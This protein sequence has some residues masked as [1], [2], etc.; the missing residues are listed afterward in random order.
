MTT[1][2]A[3]RDAMACD[4]QATAGDVKWP[5]QKVWELPNGGGLLGCSGNGRALSQVLQWF[6]DG[7][8]K[9][10]P[11]VG[12]GTFAGLL[13]TREGLFT[14]DEACFIEPVRRGFHAVGTGAGP[15]IMAIMCGKGL[16]EAVRMTC[17]VDSNS[18]GPVKTYRLSDVPVKVR[19]KK[20]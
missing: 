5:C 17:D 13:L 8:P 4:S 20:G 3:T 9:E 2:A 15:A 18:G 14:C 12:K 19:K 10:R 16:E 11:D 6:L 1:I 7:Q